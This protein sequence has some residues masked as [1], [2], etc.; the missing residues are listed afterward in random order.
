MLRSNINCTKLC[1]ICRCSTSIR[2]YMLGM[3]KLLCAKWRHFRA[4]LCFLL[5]CRDTKSMNVWVCLS[6]ISFRWVR[7]ESHSFVI[8]SFCREID[9]YSNIAHIDARLYISDWWAEYWA[10]RPLQVNS[11]FHG[12]LDCDAIELWRFAWVKESGYAKSD[13]LTLEFRRLPQVVIEKASF[14]PR[15][16]IFPDSTDALESW[17]VHGK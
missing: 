10:M 4:F 1:A 14:C 11:I 9:F 6:F 13:E 16:W 8:D 3:N 17:V 5:L 15:I 2:Q 12:S 7:Y